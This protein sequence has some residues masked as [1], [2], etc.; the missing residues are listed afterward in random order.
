[1]HRIYSDAE[2][3]ASSKETNLVV[4]AKPVPGAFSSGILWFNL[5]GLDG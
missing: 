2:S 4:I 1:M 5:V 3:R